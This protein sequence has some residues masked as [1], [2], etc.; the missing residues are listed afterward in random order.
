MQ[1]QSLPMPGRVLTVSSKKLAKQT[2]FRASG[3]AAWVLACTLHVKQAQCQFLAY[4]PGLDSDHYC[5][6]AAQIIACQVA[7]T[8]TSVVPK[9][10]SDVLRLK[11]AKCLLSMV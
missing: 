2:M 10:R 3:A 11:Q 5:L 8:S 1:V 4:E 7:P 6:N 9:T